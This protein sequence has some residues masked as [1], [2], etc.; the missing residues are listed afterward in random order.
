MITEICGNCAYYVDNWFYGY[1]IYCTLP[2]EYW[3]NPI[4]IVLIIVFIITGLIC[5]FKKKGGNRNESK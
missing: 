5:V 3:L 2:T 1:Q 4:G